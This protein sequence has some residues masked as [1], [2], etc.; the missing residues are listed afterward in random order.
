MRRRGCDDE[1]AVRERIESQ[2]EQV[3]EVFRGVE[4]A[5]AL[6][7]VFEPVIPVAL[8]VDLLRIVGEIQAR[9]ARVRFNGYDTLLYEHGSVECAIRVCCRMIISKRDQ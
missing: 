6:D 2:R 1:S 5:V 3:V 9:E 4:A 7:I 8:P